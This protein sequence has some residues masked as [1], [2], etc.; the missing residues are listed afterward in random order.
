MWRLLALFVA[1]AIPTISYAADAGGVTNLI[2]N[3]S[4]EGLLEGNGLPSGWYAAPEKFST[5]NAY[6]QLG[7]RTGERCLRLESIGEWSSIST[8]AVPLRPGA[9]Q[10]GEVWY[11]Q[12]VK[13]PGQLRIY[14]NYLNDENRE[15][16]ASPTDIVELSEANATTEWRLLRVGK[17]GSELADATKFSFVVAIVKP[18]VAVLDDFSL[19][20]TE[21]D[22]NAS[23]VP[24]GEM[25]LPIERLVKAFPLGASEEGNAKLTSDSENPHGGK[26]SI[27]ITGE[28]KWAVLQI[29]DINLIPGKT[30]RGTAWKRAKIGGA[31]FR[32]TGLEGS[33]RTFE[34]YLSYQTKPDWE[35]TAWKLTPEELG[36]AKALRFDIETHG[37]FDVNFDDIKI[38][39]E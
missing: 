15:V 34:K 20:Q 17:V 36:N 29:I 3:S 27:K 24:N 31:H 39:F 4:L 16:G 22:P 28:A 33:I 19:T 37:E 13:S 6:T 25:E 23:L 21:G 30:I 9:R 11:R 26:S 8:P 14:I 35:E 12:S 10:T 2:N 7:G 1:C 38:W 32:L 5:M 18:G